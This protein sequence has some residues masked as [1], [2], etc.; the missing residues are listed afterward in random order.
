ME[1]N[2]S[3]V[4]LETAKAR[5]GWFLVPFAF[6]MVVALFALKQGFWMFA[7]FTI[8]ALPSL[9]LWF[10]AS[11]GKAWAF[12]VGAVMMTLSTIYTLVTF[13]IIGIGILGFVTWRLWIAFIDC[14]ALETAQQ[15]A[16]VAAS[17]FALPVHVSALTPAGF[18][19]AR[20][21]ARIADE[22][23]APSPEPWKPYSPPKV[24]PPA[25]S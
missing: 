11:K 9:G 13:Q 16:L 7:I 21:P 25:P 3:R 22:V 23:D 17:R 2:V 20:L 5:A 6:W 12:F 10:F 15:A 1:D 8:V 19:G 4:G 18:S 14:A 24:D